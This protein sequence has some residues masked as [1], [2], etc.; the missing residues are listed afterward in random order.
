M[1][2]PNYSDNSGSFKQFPGIQSG[3]L[4][5]RTSS[6]YGQNESPDMARYNNQFQNHRSGWFTF[7]HDAN[8]YYQV[9]SSI[10]FIYEGLSISGSTEVN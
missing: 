9:G 10:P 8:Q 7:I 5:P 6:I 2:N 3:A 4:V 1:I